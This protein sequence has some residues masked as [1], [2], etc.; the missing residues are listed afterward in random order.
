M[1]RKIVVPLDGS[2]T[3]EAIL[4]LVVKIAQVDKAE[5]AL[6]TVLTPVA[7]W[8]T[9]ATMIKWDAEEAAAGEY[10]ENKAAELEALGL[11][12]SFAVAYG[13][14]ASAVLD[15]VKADGAD[16]VALTT[17]G[18]SGLARWFLGSVTEKLLQSKAPMLVARP[19]GDQQGQPI[20]V[21]IRKIL[22]P[23]DG[24][25]LARAAIPVAEKMAKTFNASLVFCTVTT[26]DWIAYAGIEAP[27]V[28]QDTVDDMTANVRANLEQT[29]AESRGRGFE[30][31]CFP[32]V[33]VIA[34]ETLR[35]ASEQDVGLIV[36]STH[37]RSGPSRWVMGS[38]ADALVRRSHLPCLLVRSPGTNTSEVEPATTVAGTGQED[39]SRGGALSQV[40]RLS[41]AAAFFGVPLAAQAEDEPPSVELPTLDTAYL[42]VVAAATEDV[43]ADAWLDAVKDG[44]ITPIRSVAATPGD[45]S[46]PK[47]PNT[48]AGDLPRA[49]KIRPEARRGVKNRAGGW[50][51][52]GQRYT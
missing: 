43:D 6:I 35:I 40:A 42:P 26:T 36:L 29:A 34:D 2:P 32:G 1:T 10:I 13:E 50:Y 45:I 17:H 48:R 20:A 21:E 31:E 39:G 47:P 52:G 41:A 11:K 49:R 12:A 4:P 8:D 27:A 3:A 18:R 44:Q 23:L 51:G 15:K 16:L 38:T 30:V 46:S 5:V 37:G 24:S 33:G 22:V 28:Y 9:A 19:Y 14:A 25:E 7:I